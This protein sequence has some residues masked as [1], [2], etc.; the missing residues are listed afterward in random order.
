MRIFKGD[1][2]VA[3]RCE[4]VSGP[5]WSNELVWVVIQEQGGNLRME[6]IQPGERTSEIALLMDPCAAADKAMMCAVKYFIENSTFC[7]QKS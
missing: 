2:V 1:R 4:Y 6:A 5:G 7:E 3:T